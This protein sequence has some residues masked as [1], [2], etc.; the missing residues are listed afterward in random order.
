MGGS[1]AF[2][3]PDR[4]RAVAVVGENP[5]EFRHP[6]RLKRTAVRSPAVGVHRDRVEIPLGSGGVHVAQVAGVPAAEAADHHLIFRVGFFQ[7]LIGDLQQRDVFSGVG[8]GFPEAAVLLVPDLPDLKF[9]LVVFG[10]GADEFAP[11]L[12]VLV[13]RFRVGAEAFD[14][15]VVTFEDRQEFDA[16]RVK[17]LQKLIVTPEIVNAFF[18]GDVGEFHIVAQRGDARLA[19]HIE[20]SVDILPLHF[21]VGVGGDAPRRIGGPAPEGGGGNADG[22]QVFEVS[23]G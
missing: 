8:I 16:G 19:H 7:L 23:H 17:F 5:L 1:A 11:L 3:D 9:S 21:G 2:G 18:P 22:Q 20:L 15:P 6:L 10:A 4:L 13:E 12:R 14:L